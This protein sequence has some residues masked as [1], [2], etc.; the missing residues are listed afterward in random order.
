VTFPD[1]EPWPGFVVSLNDGKRNATLARMRFERQL[2]DWIAR[3]P[4]ARKWMS[5]CLSCGR[6]GLRADAPPE[7]FNRYW[8]KRLGPLNLADDGR[9]EKCVRVTSRSGTPKAKRMTFPD[10]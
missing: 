3:D 6:V 5:T 7:F 8:W 9:C 4:R 10:A 2:S 1:T